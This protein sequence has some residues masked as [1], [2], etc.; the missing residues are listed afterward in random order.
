M[1]GPKLFL[2]C[3]IYPI[4]SCFYLSMPYYYYSTSDDIPLATIV[5]ISVG[6]VL[7]A[8]GIGVWIRLRRRNKNQMVFISSRPSTHTVY[9]APVQVSSYGNPVM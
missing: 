8:I 9:S 1:H 4:I 5:G 2:L 6:I 3:L 7:L